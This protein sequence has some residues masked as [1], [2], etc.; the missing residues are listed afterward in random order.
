[1]NL[2]KRVTLGGFRGFLVQTV[3]KLVLGDI[4][5][6][7]HSFVFEHRKENITL[8]RKENTNHS[9]WYRFFWRRA[10]TAVV[11]HFYVLAIWARLHK[12]TY[13]YMGIFC[14]H[15]LY[16]GRFFLNRHCVS[17]PMLF[18]P[19]SVD[20]SMIACKKILRN[21]GNGCRNSHLILSCFM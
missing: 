19:P 8:I 5:H 2:L 20:F 6:A 4:T 10:E 15:S 11:I 13:D 9:R 7:Q 12:A 16:F 17:D 1:M 3:L 14:N 21:T 18:I